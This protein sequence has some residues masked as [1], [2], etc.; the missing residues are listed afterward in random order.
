VTLT[1]RVAGMQQA[2]QRLSK[3]GVDAQGA[4]AGASY[5]FACQ[6]ISYAARLA[7]VVT[8][9]LRSSFYV[10]KPAASGYWQI[11][12]GFSAT[13]AYWVEVRDVNHPR[14]Q[15]HFL[16]AAL[17]K[18]AGSAQFV[19]DTTKQLLLNGQTVDNVSSTVPTDAYAGGGRLG[20][21][22]A[23]RKAGVRR[24][25]IYK[26]RAQQKSRRAKEASTMRWE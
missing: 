15:A 6:V 3:L 5:L 20:H 22:A 8:G 11:V 12:A 14:G 24:T 1:V 7:P 9:W 2:L 21:A 4:F 25:R 18:Y 23:E 26:R 16:D 13:Y 17:A 19:A 10:K